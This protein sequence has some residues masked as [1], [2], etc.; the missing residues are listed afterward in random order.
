MIESGRHRRTPVIFGEALVDV[1]HEGDVAGGAPFNVARHLAAL[2][3][4]PLF[5]TRIGDDP[6][7]RMLLD[8]L[9]RFGMDLDGV[10]I[11]AAR[12]TGEVRVDESAPGVH[13]FTILPDMAWDHISADQA[14]AALSARADAPTLLY[15]GSLAQ[16]D[17]IS[18]AAIAAL[19]SVRPGVGWCD[20]NW[21]AGHVSDDFALTVLRSAC[22]VKL[23]D[24]ELHMV[25]AWMGLEDVSL[26]SRPATDRRSAAVAK[27]CSSG[28]IEQLVVTYG[29]DGF[30]AFERNGRCTVAGAAA[31]VSRMVDTVGS[32]DAFTAIVIAGAICGWPAATALS[33]A[34]QFAAALCGVRGAAPEDL[35]FYESW[36]SDWGL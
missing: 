12:A 32:G 36:K 23:N 27:L 18:R 19:Q 31:P 35:A 21:R 8:E 2:G 11:D 1:F 24:A 22:S 6:R 14:L 28:A 17:P 20:L 16:R 7:G 9:Q 4:A 5:V 26:Q 30:A 3:L 29:A 25:L 33:R 15:Y 34:N 13:T 10:Q